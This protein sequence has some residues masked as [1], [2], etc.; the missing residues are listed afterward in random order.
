MSAKNLRTLDVRSRQQWRNWRE[1]ITIQNLRYGSSFTSVTRW[2]SQSAQTRLESL[3]SAGGSIS[4]VCQR[5][6]GGNAVIPL[7]LDS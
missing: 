5:F 6:G 1:H 3:C 7:P 2:I 4:R